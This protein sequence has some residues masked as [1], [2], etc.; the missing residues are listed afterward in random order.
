MLC[1]LCGRSHWGVVFGDTGGTTNSVVEQSGS[2][3]FLSKEEANLLQSLR[4]R[5]KLRL[6]GTPV[7]L[8]S[9]NLPF[10]RPRDIR[11]LSLSC[12]NRFP[13]GIVVINL[14]MAA[15]CL[16]ANT[17]HLVGVK[18]A[19]EHVRTRLAIGLAIRGGRMF[20]VRVG[21]KRTSSSVH[22]WLRSQRLVFSI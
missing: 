20:V 4:R 15:G 9:T 12:S 7:S 22:G 3:D 10:M 8:E 1:A 17:P 6:N 11:T 16:F 19:L 2:Y 21:R 13:L 5:R 14:D 18:C